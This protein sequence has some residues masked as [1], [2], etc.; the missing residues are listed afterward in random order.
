MSTYES[1][2]CKSSQWNILFFGHF[3]FGGGGY[4]ACC[5]N[6]T[7]VLK[8][9]PICLPIVVFTRFI[10]RLKHCY[11]ERNVCVNIEICKCLFSNLPN[12]SFFQ[13]LAV[14]DRGSETKPQVV[15]N[16]NKLT[17]NYIRIRV[18]IKKNRSPLPHL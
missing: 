2:L 16:L 11:W 4:D 6:T 18:I 3:F 13:P 5:L 7:S 9:F 8:V 17:Y 1:S 14:V 10:S 12:M 15:K